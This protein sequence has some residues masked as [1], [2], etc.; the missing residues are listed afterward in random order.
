[1]YDR[2][3]Q[4]RMFANGGMA[5]AQPPMMQPPMAQPPTSVGTGITSGLVDPAQEQMAAEQGFAAMAGGMQDMLGQI[6]AAESTEETINALRGNEASL[7]DRYS[8]LAELV[9]NAD[10]KKTPESVLALVQPT[11]TMMDMVQQESPAGGIADAM[12]TAGGGLLTGNI[13]M[14]SPV[15]APGMGEA[16]T[17]INAGEQPV[18]ANLGGLQNDLVNRPNIRIPANV[19]LNRQ[20]ITM[21]LPNLGATQ[22]PSQATLDQDKVRGYAGDYMSM[23]RPYLNQMTGGAGPGIDKRME[24][25]APYLPKQKTSAEIMGEYDELLGTDSMDDAQTQAYLAL[26][27]AGQSIAGSDKTLLGAAIDAAGEA[28]PTLSKIAAKKSADDRASK[29]AARQES[30]SREDAIRSAQLGVAQTAISDAAR[31]SGTLEGAILNSQRAA[32]EYGLKLEGDAVKAVNETAVRNWSANNQY[33]VTSTETWGK[34]DPATKKTDIIGVRRTAEG[35]KYIKD[36]KYVPVPEGYSP[37]SKD[38]FAAKYGTGAVN[39]SGAKRVN[40]LIPDIP[41]TGADGTVTPARGA[42]SG[43]NQFAGFF[44]SKGND[45]G[46]YWY[47][48]TGDPADAIK[49]PLGFIEGDE[50]DVLKVAEPDSVGRVFVTVKAGPRAG[51]TFLSSVAGKAIPGAS[52]TL[53]PAKRDDNNALISGNPLVTTVPN[54]GVSFANMTPNMVNAN[55]QK[56]IALSQALQ[57]ANEVLPI[58]G[59]AVGPLNT[60]KAWTSNIVGSVAPDSW[61]GMVEFAA[62]DRGRQRMNMMAR[63]LARGLALSDR[64]AVREQ[65]LITQLNENPEGFWKNPDMSTVRFQELMRILQN[66]LSFSRGV[67]SDQDNIPVLNA[68]PT[69]SKNDPIMFSAPGQYDYLAISAANA[70]GSDKLKGTFLRMSGDEARA[71]G[72]SVG[73]N[74]PYIDL[75]IGVDINF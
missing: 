17:R 29:L 28:A 21:T 44:V 48:P 23:M 53:E 66:E 20:P 31:A 60:V 71:R 34:Y 4:R 62:T 24:L 64:Y 7:E 50:K 38:A 59:D 12:P 39:F 41:T 69:G 33:G 3:L 6:D 72:I 8:E 30:V 68:I 51:E 61:D 75:E 46:S 11:F 74:Q 9:G 27:K 22:L 73:A 63:N 47:S 18:T 1:M 35:V 26:V 49:A 25:L 2:V 13:D 32:V 19:T 52:Y 10:A 55:Q 65:E 58:I 40:L 70:G 45:A 56:V 67:L 37:Y 16:V 54:P 43:Y 36:G 14:A 57:S 15:Q 42:Q 5:N